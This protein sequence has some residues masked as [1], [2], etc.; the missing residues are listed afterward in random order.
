[1][2]LCARMNKGTSGTAGSLPDLIGVRGGLRREPFK[3]PQFLRCDP[4]QYMACPIADMD[5]LSCA[6]NDCKD[7]IIDLEK[8]KQH[9]FA[10][11]DPGWY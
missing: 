10:C 8:A 1:L 11:V 9:A 3:L 7:G 2:D 6:L 4:V 5:V